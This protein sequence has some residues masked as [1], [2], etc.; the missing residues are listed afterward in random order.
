MSDVCV[1]YASE[2]RKVVSKL[3][4]LLEKR[5]TVWWDRLIDEGRWG[6]QVDQQLSAARLAIVVWSRASVDKEIVLAEARRAIKRNK[7]LLM[8]RIDHVELPLPVAERTCVDAFGWDGKIISDDVQDLI[9]KAER[10]VDP[11]PERSLFSRPSSVKILE[12]EI[13]LPGF[14]RSVS[15]FETQ[16]PPLA[17]LDILELH[18]TTLILVSAYDMVLASDRPKMYEVIRRMQRRGAFIIM[19]SGNYEAYRKENFKSRSN[20]KGWSRGKFAEA[21][22]RAPFDMAFCFDNFKTGDDPA[23]VIKDVIRRTRHDQ[24]S[25]HTKLICPIVHAPT[26][27]QGVRLDEKLPEILYAVAKELRP[28]VIAVPEREL[29]NGIVKR[30]KAVHAIRIALNDLSWYQPLHVLGTG[31]PWTMAVLS[32]AGADLFDG[33]EWCRTVANDENGVL[34]H[35]QQYDLFRYQA[36]L[37]KSHATKDSVDNEK[38]PYAARV[39]LHNLEVFNTWMEKVQTHT[40]SGTVRT[41]LAQ[42]LGK[43]YDDL[44]EGLPELFK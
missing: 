12:K 4:G 5:M 14:F 18:Q 43:Q 2:D 30:A 23:K 29:G 26:S 22:S 11:R 38:V 3:V 13:L 1:F 35:F 31:N 40:R 20:S 21:I 7:P 27:V 41:F 32:A 9:E 37:A 10:I 25:D 24:R 19:D 8:L 36:R 6:N 17:C 44:R 15:S 34:Y 28:H 16:I 33:L 39:A 42:T